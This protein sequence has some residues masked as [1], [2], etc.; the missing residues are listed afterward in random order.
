MA[1]DLFEKFTVGGLTNG[2]GKGVNIMCMTGEIME[3]DQDI[4]KNYLI[5]LLMPYDEINLKICF[6]LV[7]ESFDKAFRQDLGIIKKITLFHQHNPVF[8]NVQILII[9][10]Q[11]INFICCDNR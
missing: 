1:N 4:F 11:I 6:D 2:V 3:L 8:F 9:F 5:D 10:I 7:N